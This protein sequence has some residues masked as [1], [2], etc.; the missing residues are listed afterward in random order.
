MPAYVRLSLPDFI[1]ANPDAL[2]GQLEKSHSRD[3]YATQFS[4]QTTAWGTVLPELQKQFRGLLPRAAKWTVLLEFPLYRLRKRIDL[5]ILAGQLIV[6]LE[7]KVGET[8]FRAE[9]VRQVEEYALDLRDFHAASHNRALLPILWCTSASS[10]PTQYDYSD[11]QV[12]RVQRVGVNGLADLLASIP[13]Y[14]EGNAIL[15]G[16]WD[17][18]AYTP[19]PNVI[20]AATTIF[21]GHD[22]RAIAQ[23][24]ASN[25]RDSAARLVDLIV[26]ARQNRHRLLLFLTGVPGSGKTLA[27]LQVVH[28][29]LAS[30]KEVVGDIVY[31]SGNTPL[32][33]VL[34]EALAQD[35]HRRSQLGSNS[36]PLAAIRREVRTRIQHINDF[37]R[38]NLT[39]SST[40]PPHEHAI[41]F[42]EAQRAWD[43]EQGK[44]K[45]GRDASEPTLLLEL[46]SRHADWCACVCLVGG[47]Q[48]SNS[49]EQGVSGWGEALRRLPT[50]DAALWH[51]HAS[52]DVFRG[53]SSTAGLALGPVPRVTIH[54]ET[55]LQLLVPMRSYRSQRVSEW[56]TRVLEGSETDAAAIASNLGPYPIVLTRSLHEAR[57]WLRSQ[58]RGKRNY[59]LVA[60]S[61]A[62]RLRADGLGQIL[63]ATD[64]KEIAHWYLRPPGD[65]RSS[66]ALEVP[67]NQ[68]TC[69]GL[70]L[71][72]VGLCWGGDLNYDPSAN[73]WMY[74]RL[75]GAYWK[76]IQDNTARRLLLNS[77][78]VLMTRAREGMVIW[79]P[80]GDPDDAT[81]DPKHLDATAQFL[82]RCGAQPL[83]GMCPDRSHSEG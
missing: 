26:S 42:D 33:T 45:F 82:L 75:G 1:D 32:V 21:A 54:E 62:R 49:G 71:D 17:N 60:S 5:V 2:L 18:A 19:V 69:Q 6:V 40:S 77:Y 12:A 20:E 72:F 51:V 57:A 29:A 63:H 3:G 47:G 7:V 13:S 74:R 68:Y 36:R 27:G 14:G 41:V 73:D 37:L 8:I 64:G 81:R 4:R 39:S 52:A 78:R 58:A 66:C 30:G 53:G 44:M 56:V 25:L 50:K 46:M 34:R 83:N 79:V 43:V 15:A 61:G 76:M 35:D 55:T 65:I 9:D 70:E 23:A 48:E 16:D 22:V 38:D 67:A 10:P 31:L 28:D 59:G 11:E 24:D 80:L